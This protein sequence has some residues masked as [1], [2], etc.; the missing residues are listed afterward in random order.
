MEDLPYDICLPS[1]TCQTS[2]SFPIKCKALWLQI[3]PGYRKGVYQ[4]PC[5]ELSVNPFL[6][7]KR[8]QTVEGYLKIKFL[9]VT[10]IL[11]LPS[12]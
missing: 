9:P 10:K 7:S 8:S 11:L 12:L 6:F 2:S 1:L 4:L 5:V 3:H